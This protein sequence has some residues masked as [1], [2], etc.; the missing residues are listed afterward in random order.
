MS[1]GVLFPLALAMLVV[2]GGDAQAGPLC[3]D[4]SVSISEFVSCVVEGPGPA[5]QDTL[6]NVQAGL[7]QALTTSVLL[8]ASGSFCPGSACSGSEF[9]GSDP[10]NDLAIGP[11]SLGGSTSFTFD[12]I[13][14]GTRFVTLK[15]GNAFEIFKVAGPVPFTLAHQLGGTDTSHIGTFVPEPSTALLVG[16]ALLVIAAAGR[17]RPAR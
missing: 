12:Q 11:S 15:Q 8:E 6:S 16:C 14:A 9:L 17:R 13:P 4:I 2:T 1:R 10:G 3:T 5:G 7:D